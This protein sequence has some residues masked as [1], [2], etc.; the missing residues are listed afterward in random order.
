[1]NVYSDVFQAISMFEK[2]Q[3]NL[4]LAQNFFEKAIDFSAKNLELNQ[5][6]IDELL[7]EYGD[8]SI[9]INKSLLSANIKLLDV[10]FN[11]L[12]ENIIFLTKKYFLL[13]GLADLFLKMK[14]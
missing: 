11:S 9:D 14:L 2:E 10:N 6:E 1:M 5:S 3:N 4:A 12:K 7:N 8:K 13:D